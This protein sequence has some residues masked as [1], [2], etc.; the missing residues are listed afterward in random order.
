MAEGWAAEG[1][2][3]AAGP[4]SMEAEGEAGAAAAADICQISVRL[5]LDCC[6]SGGGGLVEEEEA[7]VQ[8]LS[9]NCP[10]TVRQLSGCPRTVIDSLFRFF[11]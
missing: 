1:A 11:Y 5:P 7:N 2:A 8:Q 10:A 9:S 4:A 6:G 3:G